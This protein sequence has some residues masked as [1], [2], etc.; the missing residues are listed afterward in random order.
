MDEVDELPEE[1]ALRSGPSGTSICRSAK[2][3]GKCPFY[4]QP[5]YML[6]LSKILHPRCRWPLMAL[7]TMYK[8][9]YGDAPDQW[10]AKTTFEQIQIKF[11]S[12]WT[13]QIQIQ[14]KSRGNISRQIQIW[15]PNPNPRSKNW[16]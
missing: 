12:T 8:E 2:V 1:I 14:I 16:I 10:C 11:K 6:P 7:L 5:F 4:D 13:A 3:I 9:V 15:T